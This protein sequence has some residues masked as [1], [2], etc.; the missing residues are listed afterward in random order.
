MSLGKHFA[1]AGSSGAPAFLGV[2][3]PAPVVTDVLLTVGTDPLFFFD[4]ITSTSGGPEK[5]P[6]SDL[7][8]VDDFVYAEPVPEPSAPSLVAAGSLWVLARRGSD[9]KQRRSAADP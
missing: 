2:L 8:A 1:P 6:S 9:R 5:V 7:A 3:F 4:G